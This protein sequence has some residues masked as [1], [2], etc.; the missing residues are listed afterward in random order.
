MKHV[1]L[2]GGKDCPELLEKEACIVEGELL[3]LCPRYCV[4]WHEC[5]VVLYNLI[6][7]DIDMLPITIA[8]PHTCQVFTRC[9]VSY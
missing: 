9:E 3:H 1:A 7:C 4:L 6:L 8:V 2:G 5:S